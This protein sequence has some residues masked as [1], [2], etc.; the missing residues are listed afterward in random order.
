MK[1]LHDDDQRFADKLSRATK[2]D[3][4]LDAST[5]E[6]GRIVDL[7]VPGRLGAMRELPALSALS[8]LERLD[9]SS[10]QLEVLDLSRRPK[11]LF[12]IHARKNRLRTVDLRG[13]FDV[14]VVDVRDNRMRVLDV[15][16]LVRVDELRVSGNPFAKLVATDLL[17]IVHPALKRAAKKLVLRRA[18][19]Q[20]IHY[21][22]DTHN[23]DDGRKLVEWAV[24]QPQCDPA[25]ALMIYF[26][27]QPAYEFERGSARMRTWLKSIEARFAKAEFNGA[28][29]AYDPVKDVGLDEVTSKYVNPAMN[30]RARPV[31]GSPRYPYP[32]IAG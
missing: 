19:T 23:W 25:T 7:V 22:C 27:A 2:R 18:T 24:R 15:S 6:R 32:R 28:T 17:C 9:V 1:R 20:E 26:R 8:G 29:V 13:C 10:N 21:A 3:D 12:E 16:G 4:I 14:E 30:M 5:I 11:R 31:K